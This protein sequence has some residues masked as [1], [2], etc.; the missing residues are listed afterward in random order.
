[1]TEAGRFRLSVPIL[2]TALAIATFAT[3]VGFGLIG[4]DAPLWLNPPNDMGVASMGYLAI[5][6][7][8]WGFPPTVSRDLIAPAQLSIVYTDSIPLFALALKALGLGHRL[9]LLGVFV[10]VSWVMQPLGMLALLRACGVRR[11][12]SLLMGCGLALFY[13]AW[14]MML[15]GHVSL[16]GHWILTFALA[17]SVGAAR[18]GLSK[19][20]VAAFAAL[21]A[22][23]VGVHIYHLVPVAACF[24]AACLSE[25]A[26]RGRMSIPR[27]A[28]AVASF[29]GAI[30]LAAWVFGYGVGRQQSGGGEA[31]G[32][33][34]MNLL[35]P[36]LPQA[37]TL[38]GQDLVEGRFEGAIDP[39]GGQWYEGYSYLGAGA[40]LV[41]ALGVALALA[42]H[43]RTA[44]NT[45]RFGPLV[46]ALVGLTVL[47]VGPRPYFGPWLVGDI[48]RPGGTIGE[49]LGYFRCHGR[50][51]WTVGYALIAWA[52]V[53]LDLRLGRL[54]L[55]LVAAIV[56]ALQAYDTGGLQQG[57][58]EAY[59]RRV[60]DYYPASFRD[61]PALE[62][63]D[64]RIY[65][66]FSCAADAGHR[67]W[68]AQL[69]FLA[70]RRGGST[71]STP[72]ARRPIGISCEPETI[73]LATAPAASRRLVALLPN[74][75]VLEH[76]SRR[77]DCHH[78]SA[79][80]LCGAGLSGVEGLTAI[81]ADAQFGRREL[82]R[83]IALDRGAR[84]PELQTGWS[85][86]EPAG[87]WS[88]GERS[89]IAVPAKDFGG[90]DRLWVELTA[91][92]FAPRQ[93]QVVEVWS[94]GTLRAT[95]PLTSSFA[96][97]RAPIPAEGG[98]GASI[99]LRFR[100]P[101]RPSDF[102]PASPD[103]RLLAVAVNRI[104]FYRSASPRHSK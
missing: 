57:L 30:G 37:S 1:M 6:Q 21:A 24:G 46:L 63:R 17:A 45:R 18:E 27:V 68:A 41:T 73:D 36:V 56:V 69:S 101:G 33:Y 38:F 94:G 4:N 85:I 82:V 74:P 88:D 47:A 7:T 67:G 20:R 22:T 5:Q 65:P 42:G 43:P 89:T 44:F 50:F 8:A 31:L 98:R 40:L 70:L 83:A 16:A 100:S 12:A 29:A 71:N 104:A 87:F 14:F 61:A 75:A 58:R 77:K 92:G 15:T 95:W 54:A 35:G 90:E 99:E 59:H 76:F 19:T 66:S 39:T 2:S 79:G 72:T 64:W 80:Y 10:L 13:P 55:S 48:G 11:P 3:L 78:F 34:S 25:L 103:N 81:D 96:P 84:P 53:Q 62:Q 86:P 51:F 91:L 49:W 60:A 23:A 97:Y 32:Y 93:P 28:L 9:H 52:I 26:Q 102:D